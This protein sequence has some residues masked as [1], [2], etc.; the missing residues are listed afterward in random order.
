MSFCC[1]LNGF[2]GENDTR[3]T[4]IMCCNSTGV[5]TN[6]CSCKMAR[7]AQHSYPHTFCGS[8]RR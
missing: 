7:R 8:Y 5:N 6:S 4:A 3:I 1:Q 2:V